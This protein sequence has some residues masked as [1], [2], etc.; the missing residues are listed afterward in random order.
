MYAA[1]FSEHGKRAHFSAQSNPLSKMIWRMY[2][3]AANRPDMDIL[4]DIHLWI[5]QYP[6]LVNDKHHFDVKVVDGQ[7]HLSG[8]VKT[9]ITRNYLI[10]NMPAIDGVQGVEADALYDD[11]SIRFAIAPLLPSGIVANIEYGGV[12]LSGE[13]PP[14]A[15]LNALA[16][17][18]ARIEGVRKL[19]A[20]TPS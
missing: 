7:V 10:S 13:L 6:P 5:S 2:L 11:E 17:K 15:E 19:V 14:D 4:D 8:A 9:V 1:H 18:I 3:M 16:S 20:V 12:V